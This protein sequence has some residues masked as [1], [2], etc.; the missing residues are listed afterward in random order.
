MILASAVLVHFCWYLFACF[1]RL[2][3]CLWNI[4]C[5]LLI[6]CSPTDKSS[7]SSSYMTFFSSDIF[8]F[9]FFF[10]SLARVVFSSLFGCVM[11]FFYS[12]QKNARVL[13]L[14][15][16]IFFVFFDVCWRVWLTWICMNSRLFVE[17]FFCF[18][19]SILAD[20]TQNIS[21]SLHIF[22]NLKNFIS[23]FFSPMTTATKSWR[24][25]CVRVEVLSEKSICWC[26]FA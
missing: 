14:L 16:D 11:L 3:Q 8:C 15:T 5:F 1:F 9:D 4:L 22:A 20:I 25:W 17:L 19:F 10:R 2:P 6:S 12:T 18:A 24:I 13:F 21:R 26:W 23:T 7:S